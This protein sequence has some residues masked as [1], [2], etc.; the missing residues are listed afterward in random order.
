MRGQPFQNASAEVQNFSSFETCITKGF[1]RIG[2]GEGGLIIFRP[3]DRNRR[4]RANEICPYSVPTHP[5]RAVCPQAALKPDETLRV[6]C[7]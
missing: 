3:V 7:I 1:Q 4:H 6:Y 5:C 2:G